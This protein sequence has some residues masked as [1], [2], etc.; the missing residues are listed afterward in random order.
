MLFVGDSD[1]AHAVK[2]GLMI[3][4]EA[5]DW[6]F[7][8]TRCDETSVKGQCQSSDGSTADRLAAT[9]LV[10]VTLAFAA[11][12]EHS[13]TQEMNTHRKQRGR[14]AASHLANGEREANIV[15]HYT[16]VR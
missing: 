3:C 14:P 9:N 11:C 2:S 8:N 1:G 6:R 16:D 10:R 7:G 15:G 4:N 5:N 13:E 12:S